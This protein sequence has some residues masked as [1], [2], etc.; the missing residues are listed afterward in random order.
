MQSVSKKS[1]VRLAYSLKK[2][3]NYWK[4]SCID[5][6]KTHNLGS[7]A[8]GKDRGVFKNVTDSEMSDSDISHIHC[9]VFKPLVDSFI[10]S[11][12]FEGL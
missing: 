5:R 11:M 6:T 8:Y 9:E 3:E 2:T 12:L 10:C 7:H 1:G 4:L